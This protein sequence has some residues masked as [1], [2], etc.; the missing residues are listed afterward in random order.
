MNSNTSFRIKFLYSFSSMD[1][2]QLFRKI[3]LLPFLI[4]P[5]FLSLS[6]SGKDDTKKTDIT[7]STNDTLK[8]YTNPLSNIKNI[9]DPYI[10]KANNM[11]YM[12]AT[13][14]DMGFKVWESSNMIDWTEKGLALN[15]NDVSN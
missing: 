4:F 9:G 1:K 6:C 5:F 2:T 11:Y 13:S 14:S 7:T 8:T 12:Y 15:K 3:F 10:L